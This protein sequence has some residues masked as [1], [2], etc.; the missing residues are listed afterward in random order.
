MR[1]PLA[2][3]VLLFSSAASAQWKIVDQSP[4]ADPDSPLIHQRKIVS[5][6]GETGFFSAKRIDLVWFNAETHTFRVIDNGGNHEPIFP[7]LVTAMRKNGCLAGCNG[8]FFLENDQPSGLMVASG[9]ETG[10]FGSGSLLSGVLLSSGKRKPYLLRRAEYGVF[11]QPTDLIQAG[12]FLVDQGMTVRGLSPQNSRRRTFVAHDGGKWF[13]IGL[14]D[15]LTL[16]LLGEVLTHPEFSPNRKLHR[17]L[18]LDGGT[19]SG[20]FLDR[21]PRSEPLH[22]EPFKKVRNFVG[23]VP[24]TYSD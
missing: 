21:G 10:K 17:A 19:S 23:I 16:A 12:P 5:R 24:R 3:L 2:A 6:E 13:A 20:F 1:F 15:S 7:D 9:N 11:Y 8:G 22:V 18:N 4:A 14:S